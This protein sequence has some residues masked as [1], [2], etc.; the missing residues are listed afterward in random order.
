MNNQGCFICK[1]KQILQILYIYK[2]TS[3]KMIAEKTT[4][5]EEVWKRE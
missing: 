1:S 5:I 3:L 2:T 4:D